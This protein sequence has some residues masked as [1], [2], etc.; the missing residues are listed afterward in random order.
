[1]PEPFAKR[2]VEGDLGIRFNAGTLL[3]RV[4]MERFYSAFQRAFSEHRVSQAEIAQYVGNISRETARVPETEWQGAV[5]AEL[6]HIAVDIAIE[7][8]V[9]KKERIIA[10]EGEAWIYYGKDLSET[11]TVIG[12]GGV[13]IY[14]AHASHVLSAGN[15]GDGRY[16][17]LR[18]KYPKLFVDGSYLL[19]AVGLLSRKR[20]DVGLKMFKK[21]L[22]PLA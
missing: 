3:E 11:R 6:A 7:R 10:R 14:N 22:R 17:V 19:Y 5:D 13:F 18:P 2:T 9:G 1:L 15:A 20:P 21:Y 4:G 12:T 8:H 16:E